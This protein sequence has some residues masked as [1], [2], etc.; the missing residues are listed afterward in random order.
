M[1]FYCE[2]SFV[3][4]V[5]VVMRLQYGNA[6]DRGGVKARIPSWEQLVAETERLRY[7]GCV[8]LASKVWFTATGID[9]GMAAEEGVEGA[10]LVPT[11]E[12]LFAW[13]AEESANIGPG[14]WEAGDVLGQEHWD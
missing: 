13:V 9:V 7:D 8:G 4:G 10:G 6:G 1:V 14:K 3:G 2:P 12:K 5:R 11:G